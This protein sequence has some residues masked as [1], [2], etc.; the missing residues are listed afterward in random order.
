MITSDH[1]AW[2]LHKKATG[3]S[4][5]LLT[6]FTQEG[7][8]KTYFKGGLR[9]KTRV[10]LQP[11][12]PLW[13]RVVNHPNRS[14][15]QKLEQA[16]PPLVLSGSLLYIGFYLN[17]LLYYSLRPGESFV[18]LFD[19][20]EKTLREIISAQDKQAL[21]ISL[22]LFEWALIQNSGY[23]FSLDRIA[24]TEQA[25]QP[26]NHYQFIPGL[27]FIEKDQGFLGHTL[28]NFRQCNFSDPLVLKAAK[29]IMRQA[30]DHLLEGKILRS[31]ALFSSQ[32]A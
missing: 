17:E 4:S 9:N 27:G 5:V 2:L 7:I 25:I 22:R 28:L 10:L 26:K 30:I 18:S 19:L 3:D 15:V 14:F 6:F 29:I 13:L 12:I 21:E 31:R 1:S 16:N 24:E 32:R 11:F 23:G 20:Y 8:V